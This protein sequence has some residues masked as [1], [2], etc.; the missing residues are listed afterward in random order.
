MLPAPYSS[1]AIQDT[2]A[3]AKADRLASNRRL[4]NSQSSLA[5]EAAPSLALGSTEYGLLVFKK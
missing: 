5:I 2:M 4:C 3:K 1:K